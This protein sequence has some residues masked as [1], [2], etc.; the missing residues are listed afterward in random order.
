MQ[1]SHLWL[2]TYFYWTALLPL[3]AETSF[4]TS[5]LNNSSFHSL[6]HVPHHFC[7]FVILIFVANSSFFVLFLS[8]RF[9]IKRKQM[10][11]NG[12]EKGG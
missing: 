12:R 7:F 3:G 6:F 1:R 8:L 5:P 9:E 4:S 2:A 10:V 11:F